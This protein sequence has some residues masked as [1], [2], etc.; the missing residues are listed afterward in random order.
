MTN[1]AHRELDRAVA[2]EVFGV[3]PTTSTSA[4]I[5]MFSTDMTAAWKVH[6]KACS[7]IFS[8]RKAYF[9]YLRICLCQLAGITDALVE[10]PEAL[11]LATKDT[12]EAICRAAIL[13]LAPPPAPTGGPVK[14]KSNEVRGMLGRD[15]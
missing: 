10:W 8:K 13:T 12:P 6:Q 5:D 9:A 3:T 15:L 14:R 7:W 1:E 11:A 4:M 2:R